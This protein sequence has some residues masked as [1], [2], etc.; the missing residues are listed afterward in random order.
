VKNSLAKMS[1]FLRDVRAELLKVI[2]PGRRQTFLYTGVVLAS[3]VIIAGII[4]F[5]DLVLGQVI[6]LILR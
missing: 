5:A 1:K 6:G 2:W 3:V 4:W